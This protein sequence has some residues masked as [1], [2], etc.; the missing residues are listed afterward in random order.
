MP[1]PDRRPFRR[2]AAEVVAA[3]VGLAFALALPR[4]AGAEAAPELW[5]LARAKRDVLKVATL[6]V[7]HDVRARLST[8][9]AIAEAVAWCRAT[10]VTHVYVESFR[11]KVRVSRE[12]LE[13][14]RDA[15]AQ[16]G[17]EV[18]ACITTEH[19][20]CFTD[21]G[22]RKRLA[23][24]FAHT[25]AVFDEIIIDDFFFT[26][27]TCGRCTAARGDRSWS[28]FRCDLMLEM[29]RG[30]VLA[31]ARRVNPNVTVILK[32]PLWYE[33]FHNRGYDVV[34]QTALFDKIYV[35]TETRDW[36]GPRADRKPQYQAYYLMRWLGGI[37]GA[38]TAGGW[39]DY[40]DTTEHTYVEQAVQTVLGGSPEIFLFHYGRLTDGQ[41]LKNVQALRR[42]LPALFDLAALV[43]DRPARGLHAPKPPN[44]ESIASDARPASSIALMA[45]RY[46]FDFIG[47]LGL[48]LAPAHAVD[49][50]APA[51]VFALH[52]LADPAFPGKLNKMLARGAPVAVTNGLARRLDLGE[53]ERRAL[54]VLPVKGDCRNLLKMTRE[55]LRPIRKRM[56]APLG[57]AF[58][59][60]AGVGLYL[61][62]DDVAV[63]ENFT[64]EPVDGTLNVAGAT[65]A[66]VAVRVP[67]D[68]PGTCKRE[69]ATIV[70]KGLGPRT[71]VAIRTK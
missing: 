29:S 38:K 37:G 26:T 60:P 6:F 40:I 4:A 23:D 8:D 15:F 7:A 3:L 2:R 67:P 45:D 57:M 58:D 33:E 17:L 18:S 32:Y 41:G 65:D 19:P 21:P 25:A 59:A 70:L 1:D 11:G 14:V 35:G 24:I 34:R 49:P 56:L 46:V 71:L 44:S 61:F 31:P 27:C 66:A 16:A 55:Q 20:A 54:T 68:G 69:G 47:M 39:F 10:G 62:G 63:V 36:T 48:P 50:A 64:D 52:A 51:A 42:C 22:V 13:R 12:A 53:A 28:A 5:D 9:A 30:R 43:R